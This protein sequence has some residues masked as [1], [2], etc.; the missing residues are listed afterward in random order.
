MWHYLRIGKFDRSVE[1][2]D[3]GIKLADELGAKPVQY[4]TIKALAL[5]NLGRY[6]EAW[7]ALQEEV[8]QEPFGIAMQQYGM[9]FYLMDL[10]A[11]GPA[12][13]QAQRTSVLAQKL[14]RAWMRIGM[15]NLRVV[16]LARLETLDDSTLTEIQQDLKSFGAALGRPAMAEVLL[17]RGSLEEALKLSEGANVDAEKTG[18]NLNL[19]P[20]LEL[21][22]RILLGLNRP[23]EAL[24]LADEALKKAEQTGCRSMLWRI[25]INR[26]ATRKRL[27]DEQGGIEDHLAAAR[28]L[29]ELSETIPDAE[30][31][32][33]FET[34]PLVASILVGKQT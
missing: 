13:D 25:L 17:M 14:N 15:Q 5:I 28:I 23:A 33:G 12:A 29:N 2:C 34:H 32:R 8:T 20:G 18:T 16:S 26:A 21:S 27:G 24:A 6:G 1:A 22:V 4:N 10:L 11:F 31:R 30:Q 19:I 9:A 3:L 7:K